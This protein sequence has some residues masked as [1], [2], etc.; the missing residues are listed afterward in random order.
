[1]DR[2]KNPKLLRELLQNATNKALENHLGCRRTFVRH[3][4]DPLSMLR[5]T[6]QH[7][8]TVNSGTSVRLKLMNRDEGIEA[9]KAKCSVVLQ[10]Y[11]WLGRVVGEHQ[12]E[13][14]DSWS[15]LNQGQREC[16]LKQLRSVQCHRAT[17]RNYLPNVLAY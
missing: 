3:D 5:A 12:D 16:K 1:M 2:E 9:I 17:N 15:K 6:L 4:E 7:T 8:Q 10:H 11:D 13:I 14:T